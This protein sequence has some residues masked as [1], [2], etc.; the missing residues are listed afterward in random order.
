MHLTL[1]ALLTCAALS[2][3]AIAATAPAA[4]YPDRPVK[5]VVPFA[6]AGL[7]DMMA[8]LIAQKLSES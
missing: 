2:V 6:P 7:T 4:A 8:R 5:I 1:R 3:P